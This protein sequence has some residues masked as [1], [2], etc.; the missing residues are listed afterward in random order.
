M[1]II[2]AL[3]RLSQEAYEFKVKLGHIVR[4]YL[5]K[6]LTEL[7]KLLVGFLSSAIKI[8]S[9]FFEHRPCF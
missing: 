7:I 8:Y 5:K 1:P 6:N 9:D 3:R 4:P 2:P